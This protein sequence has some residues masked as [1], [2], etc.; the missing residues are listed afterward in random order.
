MAATSSEATTAGDDSPSQPAAQQEEPV[1]DPPAA[2][3]RDDRAEVDEA[4]AVDV[5]DQRGAPPAD[6]SPARRPSTR[7]RRA[8]PSRRRAR[9]SGPEG[10]GRVARRGGVNG[11]VVEAVAVEVRADAPGGVRRPRALAARDAGA[12]TRPSAVS[13]ATRTRQNHHPRSSAPP[14][15]RARV[16]CVRSAGRHPRRIARSTAELDDDVTAARRRHSTPGSSVGAPRPWAL[17]SARRCGTSTS[18]GS[19]ARTRAPR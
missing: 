7:S 11:D 14:G 8:A 18:A 13:P 2:A 3:P 15:A 16:A 4:V 5:A 12:A 6:S 9:R 1:V 17:L 10:G 19:P